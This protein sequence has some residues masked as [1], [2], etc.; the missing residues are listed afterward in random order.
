MF[1]SFF[2]IDERIIYE[3]IFFPSTRDLF[4]LLIKR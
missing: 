4:E 3:P 1:S 2:I